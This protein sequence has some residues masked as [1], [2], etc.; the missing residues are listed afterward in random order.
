MIVT[1][2]LCWYNEPPDELAACVR[3]TAT[4]A[5]RIVAVDGAYRR[6]PG[7]K[8]M[9]SP[10]QVKA[11]Q[12]AA[13]QAGLDCVVIQRTQLWAGQVEKRSFMMAS[14]ATAADWIMVVDSD[15]LVHGDREAI[16]RLLERT[17]EHVVQV[18][19]TYPV[20]DARPLSDTAATEWAATLAGRT[21]W[22]PHFYRALPG[23]RV[24][25][26]HWHVSALVGGERTWLSAS[27]VDASY[28]HASAAQLPDPF[29]YYVEHRCLFRTNAKVLGN[30]AFC[31]DRVM[32]VERTG[33][34]DD[35][36]GLPAPVFDYKARLV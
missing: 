15:H 17:S 34:E 29:P 35:V 19:Y 12:Q 2:A 27:S 23:L 28:P 24:E 30:R 33:Q 26:F 3:A 20:N 36:P 18:G 9:S 21:D 10:A 25:R 32:V 22:T 8:P 1:A 4:V 14:A 16:H 11:I 31:N 5:D 7:A 6:Y 13:A